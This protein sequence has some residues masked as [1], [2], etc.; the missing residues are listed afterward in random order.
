MDPAPIQSTFLTNKPPPPD[1]LT[2]W[3]NAVRSDP[4]ATGSEKREA[5]RQVEWRL[6][7]F[8]HMKRRLARS[9][10]GEIHDADER[11]RVLKTEANI[12]ALMA[13]CGCPEAEFLHEFFFPARRMEYDP[14]LT[15]W[16]SDILDQ[17]R[18]LIRYLG[19]SMR[20]WMGQYTT[21]FAERKRMSVAQWIRKM[22]ERQA[23][24][25]APQEDEEED[26]TKARRQET[27]R[28]P[29]DKGT[30]AAPPDVMSLYGDKCLLTHNTAPAV[31]AVN[32]VPDHVTRK[33]EGYSFRASMLAHHAWSFSPRP[34]MFRELHTLSEGGNGSRNEIPLH[35]SLA[36]LWDR[37]CLLLRPLPAEGAAEG[38]EGGTLQLQLLLLDENADPALSECIYRNQ[39]VV[40][41]E[42]GGLVTAED[43][44]QSQQRFSSDAPRNLQTGDV[45]KLETS[46]HGKYP[47]PNR[48]LLSVSCVVNRIL[49]A[50]RARGALA[51]LFRAPPPPDVGEETVWA[52]QQQEPA[53]TTFWDVLAQDAV[54]AGV[55]SQEDGWRWVVALEALDREDHMELI[56]RNRARQDDVL[57]SMGY[58]EDQIEEIR[59]TRPKVGEEEEQITG[60]IWVCKQE[61][62]VPCNIYSPNHDGAP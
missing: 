60:E 7:A 19:E 47:L 59:A 23:A 53:N 32:I 62:Q 41:P 20:L 31:G 25:A 28:K 35:T 14:D 17:N 26:G 15:E 33:D 13:L 27:P 61:L 51:S 56:R 30:V 5:E 57:E 9:V 39:E 52:R 48:A 4:N 42:N 29:A 50:F 43:D 45:Y 24:T 38:K 34:A 37:S 11:V 46:D 16:P 18:Y 10:G 8:E 44:G 21:M 22:Q 36:T 55:L 54:D 40:E 49:H 6:G 1:E 58:D 3:L 2:A 12:R